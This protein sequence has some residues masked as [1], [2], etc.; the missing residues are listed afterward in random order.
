[1]EATNGTLK[2]VNNICTLA[3]NSAKY[4]DMSWLGHENT[5]FYLIR[6][7]QCF[8]YLNPFHECILFYVGLTVA[9][10]RPHICILAWRYAI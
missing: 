4:F 2:N 7:T 6:T 9:S 10:Q 1:L 3:I 8:C 5:I